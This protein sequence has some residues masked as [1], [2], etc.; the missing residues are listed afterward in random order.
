MMQKKC[1][2]A[3]VI[4]RIFVCAAG[5]VLSGC[6]RVSQ[7]QEYEKNKSVMEGDISAENTDLSE[8]LNTENA[9]ESES[10]IG[11]AP[12]AG[13][14]DG[15][16]ETKKIEAPDDYTDE[17][18]VENS[19]QNPRAEPVIIDADWSEYFN[20]L[21]GTAVLYDATAGEY[22]LYNRELAMTQSSPAGCV[23]WVCNKR[24]SVRRSFFC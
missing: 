6:G 23:S 10:E 21:N 19:K 17:K 5:L 12:E 1:R 18:T 11:M 14:E 9:V 15:Q 2:Y 16:T 20:G 4:S 3:K 13:K 7:V 24:E 8:A 22:I